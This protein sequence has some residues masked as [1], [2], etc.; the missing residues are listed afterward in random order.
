MSV[1]KKFL[2]Q[3]A[4][5]GI[6]TVFS[7]LFNF[8]LTPLFT[9][10][11]PSAT[12][13]IFTKMYAYASMINAV[14]AFGMESTYFRYLNKH[15]DKKQEVYNNSF[16]CIVFISL[17]FLI[18]G[19]VFV[20]PIARYLSA[21]PA[22]LADYKKYV[23]YFIG[24]LFVDAI[25]VIPFAKLRAEDR[26]F[27]YSV[28][29]FL[30]IGSFVGFNLLFIFVVPAIIKHEWPMADW[31]VSWYREKWVGYVFIS[32]LIASLV[33]FLLLLPEFFKLQLRFDRAL[34]AKMFR[35]SWPI[36]VANLSFIV[37][38]NLDKIVLSELLPEHIADHEVG[39][40]GAV[41][42]IAVFMSIF[43][44]AFRL[45]AEPFFFSY[46]KNANAKN[47]YAL[48]LH[49][50]V[51]ALALLFVGL[52]ANIE[53]LKYFI[54]RDKAHIAEYW[55][56]LP[57]VPYLLFGYVCLG[58]YMNLSIWYRLS[59]QTRFGL[60]ISVV[61]AVITIVMNF[62]LIPKYSY[63]GSAWVSMLAYFVM[64]VISYV[65][66][67][68]HYPI[69]Y[70]LKRMITYLLVSVLLVVLSFWVFNRNIYIGNT[71]LLVFFAGI[72]YFEKDQLKLILKKR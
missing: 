31:L 23:Q 49:Y 38:E 51:I 5:Y 12:Y 50:F 69:P 56:G 67:Q 30:N 18:T 37:N 42:K 47:T 64:M 28:V 54:S 55:V 1:L 8:I 21:D 41:C 60:Y 65:L 3:T 52:I 15:E 25:C 57:A 34:F 11:Y 17:L 24:I 61:G 62:V 29:K 71:M 45:G 33:T 16:L 72:I 43:I 20:N 39:I 6:S 32:N 26:A 48:I 58:I 36:L 9:R 66:G 70:D 2:G 53:L 46:A 27:K 10:A 22:Q 68:K 35:Y 4:V 13:G 63:M 40:Y 19:F 14:L 7:R 59:D 44:T